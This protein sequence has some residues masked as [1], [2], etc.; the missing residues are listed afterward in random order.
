MHVFIFLHMYLLRR[1]LNTSYIK[2]PY[3]N[4]SVLL[5]ST[6]NPQTSVY[7]LSYCLPRAKSIS[8]WSSLPVPAKTNQSNHPSFQIYLIG[9]HPSFQIHLISNH[10][11]LE[12]HLVSNHPSFQIYLISNHPSFQIYLI[13]C[14]IS[15]MQFKI[16]P[17]NHFIYVAPFSLPCSCSSIPP[18]A[19]YKK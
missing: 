4:T 14:F 1:K 2:K 3:R 18:G 7:V 11:S 6:V 8:S 9:N 10:P 13:R 19:L 17:T 15:P 16:I 5:L 12:F